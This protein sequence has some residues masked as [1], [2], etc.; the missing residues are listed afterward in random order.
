MRDLAA[1]IVQAENGQSAAYAVKT[2]EDLDRYGLIID[3]VNPSIIIE[4]GTAYG[5]SALWF[6]RQGDAVVITI[7][8]D[9]T[10]RVPL[11]VEEA[12]DA[13]RVEFIRD[14]SVAAAPQIV[15]ALTDGV[16]D[17]LHRFGFASPTTLISLDSDHHAEHVY[18]ELCAYAPLVSPGSYLVVEDTIVR[19]LTGPKGPEQY[20][21]T[22]P[23]DAVERFLAE[24]DRFVN[25]IALEDLHATTQHPGG[26]LRRTR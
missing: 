11:P 12:C 5:R 7:D 24:D 23:L 17:V 2:A 1:S 25:D 10:D 16:P 20:D 21:G 14:D 6:A 22:S 26:W 4:T 15:E 9:G 18:R 13:L 19:W 3:A 8:V